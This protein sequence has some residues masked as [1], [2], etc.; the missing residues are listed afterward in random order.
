MGQ[1]STMIFQTHLSI[2]H[3]VYVNAS[4][5]ITPDR[6]ANQMQHL[7]TDIYKHDKTS[8]SWSTEAWQGQWWSFSMQ[9]LWEKVYIKSEP[10]SPLQEQSCGPWNRNSILLWNMSEKLQECL[11]IKRTLKEE[12]CQQFYLHILFV[13]NKK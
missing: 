4:G 6:K 1:Q 5:K 12:S 10:Y 3:F 13:W 7:W 8:N 2:G 11:Q 9:W